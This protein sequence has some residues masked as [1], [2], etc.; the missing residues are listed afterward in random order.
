MINYGITRAPFLAACLREMHFFLATYNI[1][2]KA[3][4][5]ASKVNVLADLC[6]RAFS[7]DTHFE[8]FNKLLNDGTIK[9]EI[10]NYKK[11]YFES[12]L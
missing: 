5:I 4:Y 1:E 11:L 6:S 3:Q 9:L 8:N 10:F 7:T 12:G 2:L